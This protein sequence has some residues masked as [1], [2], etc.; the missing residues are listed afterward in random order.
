MRRAISLAAMCPPAAGAYSVGALI[1]DEDGNEI[2]AGYSRESDPREH[3]EEAALG[4][5]DPRLVAGA[6]LYSTLEPCSQRHSPRTPCAQRILEAGI[7]RVV[8]AWREPSLFVD[9]CIGYE[10]LVEAGVVVVELHELA[11]SAKE[12]NAHLGGLA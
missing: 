12:V 4:K 10:Q 2:A 11:A 9:D 1:V 8:I 5:A 7:P 6:T 3:A